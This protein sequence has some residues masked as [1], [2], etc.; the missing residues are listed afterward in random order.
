[1]EI[2]GVHTKIKSICK[3]LQLAAKQCNQDSIAVS[4]VAVDEMTSR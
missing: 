3:A 2:K 1:M 4:F